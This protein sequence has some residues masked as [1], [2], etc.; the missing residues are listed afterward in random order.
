MDSII[1][2][3]EVATMFGVDAKT[4]TRWANEGKLPSFR[5]PGGHVRFRREDIEPLTATTKDE[6]LV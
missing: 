1:G 4:V 5:T 3:S 2:P 6:N